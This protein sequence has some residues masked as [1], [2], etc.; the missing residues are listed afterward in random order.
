MK[1][2]NHTFG[3]LPTTIFEKMTRLAIEHQSINLAQGFPD[4][5]LEGPKA[6]LDKVNTSMQSGPNQYAPMLG[7]EELRRSVASHSQEFTKISIDW[8]TQTVITIGATEALASSFLGLLN[9][10]DE[11]IV[12]AP[13]YD[14]YVPM[15][16]RAGGTAKIVNLYP[17]SW[18]LDKSEVE[19]AFS[20]NTKL[21]VLNTPHN[22]T[23]KVFKKEEL[24]WISELC[25]KHNVYVV[26]DEVY[27]FATYPGIDHVSMQSLDGMFERCLRIGSA[28]KT[29]SFTDFKIGWMTGPAH[30]I[31][32]VA[33]A[34]QFIV[35]SVNSAL[36]KAVAHGLDN[37]KDF[38]LG[39]VRLYTCK[40]NMICILLCVRA[41]VRMHM[42]HN[43]GNR[44]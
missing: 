9:P 5:E 29:F 6:M 3:S 27:Q 7:I 21:L 35:F 8:S 33:K 26:L 34:H 43:M 31:T 44:T 32:A 10:G 13:M 30:L 23:G 42:W 18:N 2:A 15:I 4:K 40:S 19:A 39:Y 22:P 14:S 12:I 41:C 17:P 16:E 11:A 25:V 38:Y 36:Q 20:P 28:G 24:Q 37:E 1:A